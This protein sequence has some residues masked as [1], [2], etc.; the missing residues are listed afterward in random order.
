MSA[1]KAMLRANFKGYEREQLYLLNRVSKWGN[2]QSDVDEIAQRVTETYTSL[3]NGVP[4]HR[5]GQFTASMFTLDHCFTLGA[6]HRRPCRTAGARGTI[7]QRASA[8]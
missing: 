8:P 6:S 2:N 1:L 3:V 4:N 7:L 5:G